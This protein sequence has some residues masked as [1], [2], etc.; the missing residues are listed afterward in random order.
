M[1]SKLTLEIIKAR[2][3]TLSPNIKILSS[4]YVS[5]NSK[6]ECECL[7]CNNTWMVSW[8][9]LS[10]KRGCPKCAG[11]VKFD[12]DMIRQELLESNRNIELLSKKYI[13]ID[14]KLDFRCTI[15][16]YTWST[17][18]NSIKNI[19]TGCAKCSKKNK[20]T[21]EEIKKFVYENQPNIIILSS[22][23]VKAKNHLDC[24]CLVCNHKWGVNWSNLSQGRGCPKCA[25]VIRYDFKYIKNKI[26]SMYSNV[27]LSSTEYTNVDSKLR[28]KCC[29]HDYEWESSYY[30]LVVNGNGCP[31]CNKSSKILNIT[32]IKARLK[33][34]NPIIEILST[35]Y[36][37]STEKLKCKCLI[38]N[39]IFHT[40]WSNLSQG[41]GCPKCSNHEKLDINEVVERLKDINPN[42]N[43]IS[44]EYDN[45]DTKITYSCKK[46]NNIW[47]AKWR[48][49]S[50][51][52]GCPK[53]KMSRGE[54][55]I[56]AVLSKF[57]VNREIQQKYL[58]LKGLE[59]GLSYDF[60]LK[61]YNLLIEFQG[62]QHE[63]PVKHFGGEK[64]FIKQQE[65]D[66]RKREYALNNNIGLLE[67]WYC[68]Y[69]NIEEIL[70]R[71]LNI[72]NNK[73]VV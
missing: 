27:K 18:W 61:D 1:A 16:G 2:L 46:C 5:A 22:E 31:I 9:K 57:N 49:L 3:K 70:K 39:N 53:C 15:D 13:N 44:R 36:I 56:E 67:I 25:N 24:K 37:N 19:G 69:D 40:N 11:N 68:D 41:R 7:V 20:P 45:S 48:D 55:K 51:G 14:S 71:E 65:Y 12:I 38:D 72:E 50:Q 4:E 32:I 42:I 17:S 30:S 47:K 29:I 33:E 64:Q 35:V 8:G 73:E 63:M 10:Q 58:D 23:Y 6:L 26:E 54:T 59:R 66:K 21:I 43:I 60:Y 62:K 52:S 28:V 34:I